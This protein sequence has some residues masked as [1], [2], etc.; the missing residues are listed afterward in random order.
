MT[1]RP[2]R[3][4]PLMATRSA[5]VSSV[6]LSSGRGSEI[7]LIGGRAGRVAHGLDIVSVGIEDKRRVVVCVIVRAQARRPVVAPAG[8]KRCPVER[9]DLRLVRGREREVER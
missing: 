6:F 2:M 8:A 7:L 1:R 3:P 5:M 4:T 9:I